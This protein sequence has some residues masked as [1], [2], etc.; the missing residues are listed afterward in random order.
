M[1]I[2]I[3]ALAATM[4]TASAQA[5]VTVLTSQA[6]FTAAGSIVQNTNFDTNGSDFT[7]P[8]SPFTVG[9][10]TFVAG[11]QNLIGG[12]NGYGFAR[13]LFTDNNVRGTT[14]QIAG[15]NDLFGFNAGNFFGAGTTVIDIVTNLGTYQFT[16]TTQSYANG[17]TLTFLGYQAG[18]GEYFKSVK[19][20]GG[21]ATGGTD[22]Q[23][24]TTV[25]EPASWALMI[26][27]FGL[28]G[29]TLR[30]RTA[31]VA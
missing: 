8:G 13:S 15:T 31:V 4:M 30:R 14:V 24:G 26:V 20:S 6:V 23:I 17:G 12:M 2:A 3:A 10:L 22:F 5:T 11:G 18:P 9:A 7:F 29:A 1:K 28:V 27:G 19:Y 16:P 21:Q 25:P